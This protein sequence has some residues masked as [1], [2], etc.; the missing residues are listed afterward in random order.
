MKEEKNKIHT[1]PFLTAAY[2]LLISTYFLRKSKYLFPVWRMFW[3]FV[4]SKKG[5]YVSTDIHGSRAV[6]PV[7]H[8]YLLVLKTYPKFNSPLKSLIRYAENIYSRDLVVVDVGSAV[9]DT[10][11]LIE[12]ISSRK[13]KYICID[14]DIEYNLIVEN[15]LKHLGG[16]FHL[17]NSLVS[18]TDEE[19]GKIVKINPTTGT[20]NSDIKEKASYLDELL[21]NEKTID[22]IKIDIDGFDGRAISGAREI[23][24]KFSPMVI[25][26]WNVPLYER[27]DNNILEPFKVLNS[28]GYTKFYWFD[29]FGNF[30]L[31]QN[32]I[33]ESV[34]FEMAKLS[35]IKF[36]TSGL[37]YDVVAVK[38][39]ND[40]ISYIN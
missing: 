18:S 32:S 31:F 1:S 17:I 6:V 20:A 24:T 34:L 35:S 36:S 9:G 25:F 2:N 37:H 19:I 39:S 3:N 10:V 40:F 27:L 38:E 16:R 8:W 7:G 33:E 14:G 22:V 23:L 15:N 21:K 26:E 12:E 30:L 28:S 13:N 5:K 11:L 29:N 4:A